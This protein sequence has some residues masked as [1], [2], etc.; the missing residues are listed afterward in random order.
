MKWVGSRASSSRGSCS[1]TCPTK[2]GDFAGAPREGLMSSTSCRDAAAFFQPL[3]HPRHE[4][5]HVQQLVHECR[6]CLAPV[7]VA[8]GEVAHDALL[9][10]DL[11]LVPLV[12]AYGRLR[13]LEDGVAHVDRVAKED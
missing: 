5:A 3:A 6:E 10:V 12:N 1:S 4:P 2:S 8:L 9:E 13:R 11:Q 7:L